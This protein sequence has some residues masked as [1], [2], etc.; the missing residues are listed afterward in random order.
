[1]INRLL[2]TLLIAITWSFARAATPPVNKTATSKFPLLRLKMVLDSFNYDDIAIGFD[3]SAT[4]TYNNQIDSRYF[5][6]INAPEGLFSLSSD[7]VPLSVNILPLPKEAPLMIRLDVE[8]KNS[9]NFDMQRTELDSISK[10]YDIWLVDKF[11]KDSVN[12]RTATGYLFNINKKDSTSFGSNRFVVV[13]RQNRAMAVHL[14]DFTAINFNTGA[15]LSWTTGN[16][17]DNTSFTVERSID[18]GNTFMAL[19]SIT[20]DG[21]GVYS[22]IDKTPIDGT[23]KYRLKI[24]D[25]NGAISYS[26]IVALSIGSTNTTQ[27]ETN[28]ISIYPNPSNGLINLSIN[29]NGSNTVSSA[30]QTTQ[31]NG[32]VHSFAA[33]PATFAASYDIKIININGSV[34]K[35]ASSVSA[36]WHDN[37]SSLSPGTYIIQVVNNA[38]KT[39]VGKSTFIKL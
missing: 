16:E 26:G 5:P 11:A 35:T 7:N 33:I 30:S 10:V 3:A 6:G 20:S 2:L 39:L 19:D 34:I 37:V 8:A 1:M 21:S 27:A 9:G 4:T 38:D 15:K 14:L 29:P 32:L 28:N 36:S 13:I 17:Q 22:Y 24:T 31:T 18:D 25:M 23:D 12:L